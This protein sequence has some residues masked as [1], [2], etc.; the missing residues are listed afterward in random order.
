MKEKL[1]VNLTWPILI[2]TLAWTLMAIVWDSQALIWVALLPLFFW[3][4]LF[5]AMVL[6]F[7][8]AAINAWYRRIPITFTNKIT[9]KTKVIKRK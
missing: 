4:G 9:G 6:L 7:V 2:W 8:V 5:L 1:T 3:A